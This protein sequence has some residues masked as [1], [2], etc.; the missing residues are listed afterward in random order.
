MGFPLAEFWWRI[1]R[2]SW[3]GHQSPLDMA[4]AA[5]GREAAPPMTGHW[6][7]SDPDGSAGLDSEFS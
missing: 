2:F 4:P 1:F 3:L 6:V 7:I 5:V